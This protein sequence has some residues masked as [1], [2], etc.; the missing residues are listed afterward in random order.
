MIAAT[1]AEQFLEQAVQWFGDEYGVSAEADEHLLVAGGDL[2][3][4][5]RGDPGQLLAV[6]Q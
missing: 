4:G 1:V 5:D 3:G 2:V 6:E